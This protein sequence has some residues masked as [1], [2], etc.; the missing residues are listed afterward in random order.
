VIDRPPLPAAYR[1][2]R[3]NRLAPRGRHETAHFANA[4][5]RGTWG[6]SAPSKDEACDTPSATLDIRHFHSITSE[7]L[8]Y[9]C[10][11]RNCG[12]LLFSDGVCVHAQDV[13]TAVRSKTSR[14]AT[15]LIRVAR[16]DSGR[17]ADWRPDWGRSR[18]NKARPSGYAE[19]LGP[20]WSSCCECSQPFRIVNNSQI[21]CPGTSS[22]A[23]YKA[24]G[25]PGY[26]SEGIRK[27]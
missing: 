15:S 17:N 25:R 2:V 1:S 24:L 8:P 11:K 22:I 7:L 12:K 9:L 13:K 10:T 23:S 20:I 6:I 19:G 14:Y 16:P 18:F 21:R 27:C 5:R 26:G 3:N 4:S